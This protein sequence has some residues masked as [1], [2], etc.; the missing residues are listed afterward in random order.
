MSEIK[1]CDCFPPTDW[2]SRRSAGRTFL[3]RRRL[4]EMSGLA[5]FFVFQT[6]MTRFQDE[7]KEVLLQEAEARRRAEREYQA[8]RGTLD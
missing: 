7:L 8:I 2:I 5:S 4:S 3:R 6:G 1:I